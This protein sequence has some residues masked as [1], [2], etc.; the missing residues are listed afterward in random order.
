MSG[1]S[2]RPDRITV[3]LTVLTGQHLRN[4]KCQLFTSN[5]RVLVE[6]SSLYT[7][8]DLSVAWEKPHFTDEHV[9]TLTNPALLIE[10]LSPST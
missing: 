1:V 8:P 10:V 4:R 3:N 6:A 2:R 9:D 7:Y 5:M